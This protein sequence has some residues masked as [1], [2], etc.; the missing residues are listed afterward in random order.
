MDQFERRQYTIAMEMLRAVRWAERAGHEVRDLIDPV[1][2]VL[3][4]IEG[5]RASRLKSVVSIY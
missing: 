1:D 4:Y 3:D 2:A 5:V